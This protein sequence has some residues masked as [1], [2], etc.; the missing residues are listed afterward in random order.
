[1]RVSEEDLAV[2]SLAKLVGSE[3][4]AIDTFTTQTTN[5]PA[6]KIDPRNFITGRAAAANSRAVMN[7]GGQQVVRHNGQTFYAGVDESLVM[8]LHPDPQP[9]APVPAPAPAPALGRAVT[10][11][12]PSER[13]VPI[14]MQPA[15]TI[16]T[17]FNDTLIK[18]L[19]SIDKTLKSIV[20]TLQPAT[21]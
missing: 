20:K 9:A 11:Q 19:K 5:G 12:P 6:N 15:A 4:H 10:N 7:R 3:L 1:M 21:K 13:R 14:Q 18:T 16:N 2:A 8:S 17:E